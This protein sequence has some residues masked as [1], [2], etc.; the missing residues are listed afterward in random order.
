[1]IKSKVNGVKYQSI[2]EFTREWVKKQEL[3]KRFN[4]RDIAYEYSLYAYRV[5]KESRNPFDDTIGRI[6]RGLRTDEC[7]P[8]N[9]FD[10]SKAIWWIAD[11]EAN[12][13]ERALYTKK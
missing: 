6:L 11:H 2:E 1:M 5:A 8:V 7:Y 3:T 9:Y 4:V 13:E 12:A 10:K